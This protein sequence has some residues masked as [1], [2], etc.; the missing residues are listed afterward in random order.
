MCPNTWWEANLQRKRN[1]GMTRGEPLLPAHPSLQ[2]PSL[3]LFSKF[4]LVE[5]KVM[6]ARSD[7]G[8]VEKQNILHSWLTCLLNQ[9]MPGDPLNTWY[10]SGQI[11]IYTHIFFTVTCNSTWVTKQPIALKE[12]MKHF[13]RKVQEISVFWEAER[14]GR[15]LT[16]VVNKSKPAGVLIPDP[17]KRSPRQLKEILSMY[18]PPLMPWGLL[19]GNHICVQVTDRNIDAIG[20]YLHPPHAIMATVKR[21]ARHAC[22]TDG[23]DTTGCGS[24]FTISKNITWEIVQ[25]CKEIIN[26]FL[27][28]GGE[29]AMWE[30]KRGKY[31]SLW[32]YTWFGG[33]KRTS[34]SHNIII[35]LLVP[36]RKT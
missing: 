32:N 35:S 2:P 23:S 13:S 8:K 16:K 6:W 20:F 24:V 33:N 19:E 26:G 1:V 29:W 4:S 21:K 14:M 30:T 3:T 36:P 22:C 12:C 25:R 15:H 17:C 11:P 34:K 31:R 9:T 28:W 7:Y 27:V 18:L 10:G 5:G